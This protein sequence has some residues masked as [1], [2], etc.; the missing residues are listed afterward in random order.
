MH[1]VFEVIGPRGVTAEDRFYRVFQ[2]RDGEYEGKGHW[3]VIAGSLDEAREYLS[4]RC[5]VIDQHIGWEHAFVTV[6]FYELRQ[7][8]GG[9]EEGGWWYDTGEIVAMIPVQNYGEIFAMR[10]KL[11]EYGIERVTWDEA[12]DPSTLATSFPDVRPHYE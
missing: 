2:G 12:L 9:P 4:A 6:A 5:H 3:D 10:D 7:S 8:Y 1:D 11:N